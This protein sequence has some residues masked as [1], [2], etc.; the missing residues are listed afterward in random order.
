MHDFLHM[1][2]LKL[3]AINTLVLAE[4][5][6]VTTRNMW[7]VQYFGRVLAPYENAA[8]MCKYPWEEIS[9]ICIALC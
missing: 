2:R 8:M 1:V 4:I 9:E 5:I 6:F 7:N 3:S